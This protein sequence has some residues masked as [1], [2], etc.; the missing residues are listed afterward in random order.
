MTR[1]R[2]CHRI[3]SELPREQSNFGSHPKTMILR[4]RGASRRVDSKQA[5][6]RLVT[7]VTKDVLRHGGLAAW[8]TDGTYALPTTAAQPVCDQMGR[9]PIADRERRVHTSQTV[10]ADAR[11]ASL[12]AQ[13]LEL[14]LEPVP[15]EREQR[16]VGT[17]LLRQRDEMGREIPREEIAARWRASGPTTAASW[18]SFGATGPTSTSRRCQRC[19]SV[20]EAT[21]SAVEG[22]RTLR[23]ARPGWENYQR[24]GGP[25]LQAYQL[26]FVWISPKS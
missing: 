22:M 25:D 15:S 4:R 23:A 13:P 11:Y 16:A 12:S 24:S 14:P 19:A 2:V 26:A 17:D 8:E 10:A 1:D 5:P 6:L 20:A 7:A 9:G 21:F 18:N 3:P